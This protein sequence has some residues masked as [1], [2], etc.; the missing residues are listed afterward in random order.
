MIA[1]YVLV[2]WHFVFIV[3]LFLSSMDSNS[4]SRDRGQHKHYW[5]IEE[6]NA[7]MDALVKLLANPI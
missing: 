7:L 6:D 1:Q 3:V 2:A 4:Q 5:T